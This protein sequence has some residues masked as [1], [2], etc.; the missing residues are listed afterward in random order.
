MGQLPSLPKKM[1]KGKALEKGW[2]MQ[3]DRCGV[4][5]LWNPAWRNYISL[6]LENHTGGGIIFSVL[7]S[8]EIVYCSPEVWLGPRSI[9]LDPFTKSTLTRFLLP[10]STW[11]KVS[12]RRKPMELLDLSGIQNIVSGGLWVVIIRWCLIVAPRECFK[13]WSI[14]QVIIIKMCLRVISIFNRFLLDSE[15]NA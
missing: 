3:E 5:L 8:Q 10:V 7:I 15:S 9:R 4:F 14:I 12:C 2:G 6:S 1:C 11:E 13:T